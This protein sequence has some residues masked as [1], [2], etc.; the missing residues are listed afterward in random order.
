[1]S[2]IPVPRLP[3]LLSTLG[4]L[5]KIVE[6]HI[7]AGHHDGFKQLKFAISGVKEAA[8]YFYISTP[9][10]LTDP[11]LRETEK[12]KK[13]G[14][15]LDKKEKEEDPNSID[16][17]LKELHSSLFS[18]DRDTSLALFHL[19][20]AFRP[21]LPPAP[22]KAEESLQTLPAGTIR[23]F[24]TCPDPIWLRCNG[25]A[26]RLSRYAQ[27]SHA[28]PLESTRVTLSYPI[29][30]DASF[31]IQTVA[32]SSEYIVA[33]GSSQ[34][35]GN[36]SLDMFYAT[37][38][39]GPWVKKTLETNPSYAYQVGKMTYAKG[40]F[41]IPYTTPSHNDGTY[42]YY[43]T[44]PDQQWIKKNLYN[45]GYQ[46]YC[47]SIS[48]CKD[49]LICCCHYTSS[50]PYAFYLYADSVDSQWQCVNLG[51]NSSNS[52]Y[53]CMRALY[54][55]TRY[56]IY[57]FCYTGSSSYDNYYI[58]YGNS[59]NSITST[60][61]TYSD[62]SPCNSPH[63]GFAYG[64]G[65]YVITLSKGILYSQ[66]FN[67][68]YSFIQYPPSLYQNYV[69]DIVFDGTQ[70]IITG[71]NSSGYIHIVSFVTPPTSNSTGWV[72]TQISAQSLCCTEP[73]FFKDR[74]TPLVIGYQ[75]N[76]VSP[77]IYSHASTIRLPIVPSSTEGDAYIKSE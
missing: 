10:P 35:S 39:E 62:S 53:R 69:N 29:T 61:S 52:Q 51:G 38:V 30:S 57:T 63:P 19:A 8:H 48:L 42:I 45:H 23:Y 27:L 40:Y 5:Q 68:G 11:G 50:Y 43:A 7:H 17:L 56:I 31:P 15:Q 73:F 65:Y 37:S 26:V 41:I 44:Q 55:G 33:V 14:E 67:T 76:S 46:T 49:T 75:Q 21:S 66:T 77:Q 22:P 60:S 18:S 28:F 20:S 36:Y 2:L 4:L 71:R 12:M 32:S 16:T 70:F 64:N 24:R 72:S 74:S 13:E 58:Y 47:N 25:S 59:P 34:R 1:M 6:K 3:T 9:D 54:D